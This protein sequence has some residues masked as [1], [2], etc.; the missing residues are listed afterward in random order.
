ME[1]RKNITTDTTNDNQTTV[2]LSKFDNLIHDRTK[3]PEAATV[4]IAI[5]LCIGF[6]QPITAQHIKD[7]IKWLANYHYNF[8]FYLNFNKDA[9]QD[10]IDNYEA[11][12]K[13]ANVNYVKLENWRQTDRWK[14][15]SA[16]YDAYYH[17]FKDEPVNDKQETLDQLHELDAL[18]YCRRKFGRELES[19]KKQKQKPTSIAAQNNLDSKI[20]TAAITASRRHIENEVK[21]VLSFMEDKD[22]PLAKITIL[23]YSHDL[24]KTM[25]NAAFTHSDEI[26]Y[27]LGSFIHAKYEFLK[28]PRLLREPTIEEED[29]I[30]PKIALFK[31]LTKEI[32]SEQGPKAS[33]AFFKECVDD[34]LKKK[35]PQQP[36]ST[37]LITNSFNREKRKSPPLVKSDSSFNSNDELRSASSTT[38]VNQSMFSAPAAS[39]SAVVSRNQEPPKL[40]PVPG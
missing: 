21:D 22:S 1:G 33:A 20:S 14:A 35:A 18:H 30:E 23:L 13:S 2:D 17:N 27:R 6:A 40:S 7:V 9:R 19:G 10:V 16:K 31:Q 36:S 39:E 12:F 3:V 11:V 29:S 38:I 28:E 34:V 25:I 4:E 15:A 32:S 37:A 26:G 8:T 5:P 24:F